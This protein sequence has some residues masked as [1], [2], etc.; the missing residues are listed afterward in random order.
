MPVLSSSTTPIEKPSRLISICVVALAFG[1][2]AYSAEKARDFSP[3]LWSDT[4]HGRLEALERKTR[5][6]ETRQ[7]SGNDG[8]VVGTMSPIA[9]HVG[10]KVLEQGGNASDAAAAVALTQVTRCL[11]SFV[12]YAGI[13]QALYFDAATGRVHSLDGGWQ[14]YA[15][16][17][18]PQT[19]PKSNALDRDQGRKTLV[20]GFMASI[21]AFQKRFGSV[22]LAELLTP[23]IWYAENGVVITPSL[24]SYFRSRERHLTRTE[25]GRA[26]VAQAG[27]SLPKAGDRFVQ[28]ELAR[29]LR[30]VATSGASYMYTGAW[31]AEFVKVVQSEGGKVTADDLARYQPLWAEPLRTQFAGHD[32]FAPGQHSEGG[33]QALLALNL[34][35]E[36][37][38]HKQ[39]PYWKDPDAFRRLS[40]VL[41]V[42]DVTT[43]WMLERARSRGVNLRR[44]ERASKDFAK[45]LAPLIDGF[46]QRVEPTTTTPSAHTAGIVVI[47]KAGNMAVIVHSINTVNWGSAGIVVGGI[48]IP[49]PAAGSQPLLAGQKPGERKRDSMTPLIVL[50]DGKPVLGVAI[51]GYG[52]RRETVRLVHGFVGQQFPLET[53]LTAPPLIQQA[54]QPTAEFYV[55][56][57]AYSSDFL[58][59]LRASSATVEVVT[60]VVAY[61]MRGIG[62][63]AAIDPNG[64]R[65]SVEVPTLFNFSAGHSIKASQ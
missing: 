43:D 26:F 29:T 44:D 64:V 33:Y 23:A 54:G 8:L 51:T 2:S 24:A 19:I 25:A 7:V 4:E 39:P 31:A 49:D 15:E 56:G 62:A 45:A 22:P 9:V 55:P 5:P 21:D 34:I 47:D 60:A 10:L 65:Y 58:N 46:F 11:G 6:E 52:V 28:K 57:D 41:N 30:G 3:A 36:L 38:L 27:G 40:R 61:A 63:V 53:L 13:L 14:S 50:R 12:S 1:T 35:E 17:T 42:T 59:Q 18:E 32:V 48:P 37:G 16:E 20:P